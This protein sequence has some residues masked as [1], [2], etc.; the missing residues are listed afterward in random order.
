MTTNAT[1]NSFGGWGL[2]PTNHDG[3]CMIC[4]T[5]R[6]DCAFLPCGHMSTCHECGSKF[7]EKSCPICNEDVKSV[8]EI[9]KASSKI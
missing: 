5:S 7:L 1:E 9:F 3:M 2:P 6:M 8:K 4:C